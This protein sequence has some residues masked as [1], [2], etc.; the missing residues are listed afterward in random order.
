MFLTWVIGLLA[1]GLMG[2]TVVVAL[3]Y[4]A[5]WH[6]AA[7]EGQ[8]RSGLLPFHVWTIALSYDLLLLGVVI[9]MS[10]RVRWWHVV[11]DLPALI[12]G[13]IAMVVVSRLGKLNA[14]PPKRRHS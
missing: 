11:I 2:F 5:R 14:M 12:L 9:Q 7:T 1:G 6:V 4:W 10:V 8:A 13:I 3:R